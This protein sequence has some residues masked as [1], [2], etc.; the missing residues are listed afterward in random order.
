MALAE[1]ATPAS[2]EAVPDLP[3]C[4]AMTSEEPRVAGARYVNPVCGMA[5]DIASPRPVHH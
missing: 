1:S 3:P 2:G 4:E 5:V